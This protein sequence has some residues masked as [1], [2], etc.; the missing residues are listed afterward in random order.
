MKMS[1]LILS[2]LFVF[3]TKSFGDVETAD[4]TYR[5]KPLE[6]KLSIIDRQSGK[7]A[8]IAVESPTSDFFIH[9]SMG[10]LYSR[11]T[12]A[13]TLIDLPSKTAKFTFHI[14]LVFDHLV[15]VDQLIYGITDD[16]FLYTFDI[17]ERFLLIKGK[18]G[19]GITSFVRYKN[20]LYGLNPAAKSIVFVDPESFEMGH[21]QGIDGDPVEMLF[22]CNNLMVL[23]ADSKTLVSFN[24]AR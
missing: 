23:D 1:Y 5:V 12:R 24:L 2:I 17:E 8:D 21:I 9:A 4:A 10:V 20:T 13:L 22:L 19:W 14:G 11:A 3:S 7:V 6:N 16:G 15:Q 18:V